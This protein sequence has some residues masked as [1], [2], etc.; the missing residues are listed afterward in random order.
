[1]PIHNEKFMCY[2]PK[3]AIHS[4]SLQIIKKYEGNTLWNLNIDL[5]YFYH[6]IKL[7]NIYIYLLFGCPKTKNKVKIIYLISKVSIYDVSPNLV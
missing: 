1:M 6:Q 4:L 3:Q 2:L 5:I 7:K